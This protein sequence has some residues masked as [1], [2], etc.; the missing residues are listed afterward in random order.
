METKAKELIENVLKPKHVLP[1]KKGEQI[2]YIIDI[3][4]KWYRNYFYFFSTYACPGPNALSPSFES[5]F[6]RMEY[7][8]NDKFALYFMRHTGEWVG[9]YDALSVDESMKA[10]QDDGWFVP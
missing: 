5:K 3:G 2:N 6:A 10:I 4:A 1:P 7:L 8:G 9:I